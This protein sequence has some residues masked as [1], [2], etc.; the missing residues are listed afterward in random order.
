MSTI[1]NF[2]P[3][4]RSGMF[5]YN[6]QDHAILTGIIGANRILKNNNLDPWNVNIDAEYHESKNSD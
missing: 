2:I 1:E 4:G 6:N 5:K 3:I